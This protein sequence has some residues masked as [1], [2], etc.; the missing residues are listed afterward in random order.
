MK[1]KMVKLFFDIFILHQ[2][3]HER[4]LLHINIQ[5]KQRSLLHIKLQMKQTTSEQIQTMYMYTM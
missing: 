1:E 3:V 2:H 4:A 5:M